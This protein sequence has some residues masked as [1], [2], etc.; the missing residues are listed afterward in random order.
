MTHESPSHI[1]DFK[2]LFCKEF[3]C[4]PRRFE[5]KLF[6][7]T[8]NPDMK[9]IALLLRCIRPGFFRR[10][11]EYIRLLGA[12]RTKADIVR[13]VNPLPFDPSFNGGFL[14]GFLRIRISARRVV[15]ITNQ[16]FETDEE[17][18]APENARMVPA[19]MQG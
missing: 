1:R 19:E 10:D 12:A 6:W 17:E 11:F 9:P 13:I 14:R 4:S 3:G 16:L 7:Q 2:S 18:M 15:Q 5:K 8:M